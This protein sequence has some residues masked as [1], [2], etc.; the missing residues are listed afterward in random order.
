MIELNALP[1]PEESVQ[2]VSAESARRVID[3]LKRQL[4]ATPVVSRPIE[5]GS[6]AY[7]LGLAFSE[8]PGGDPQANSRLALSCFDVAAKLFSPQAYPVL[9]ARVIN[10]AGITLR[11][12]GNTEEAVRIFEHAAA[13]LDGKE[14]F[15]ERAASLNNLGLAK[16]ESRQPMA[17]LEA[18]ESALCVLDEAKTTEPWVRASMVYNRGLAYCALGT[19]DAYENAIKDFKSV[20]QAIDRNE[21]MNLYALAWHNMGIAETSMAPFLEGDESRRH[22][23]NGIEAFREALAIYVRA[24][25]P[26]Q[27]AL[28][29]HNQSVAQIGLGDTE[30]LQRALVNLDQALNIF[31]PRLHTDSWKRSYALISKVEAQLNHRFPGLTRSDHFAALVVTSP[32]S[33]AN[34]LLREKFEYIFSLPEMARREVLLDVASSVVR[35]G[36]TLQQKALE[37]EICLLMEFPS[38]RLKELLLAQLESHRSL[39]R[40]GEEKAN[41]ALDLSIGN[42][43]NTPQRVFVRDFL[44]SVGFSRP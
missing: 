1:N 3:E 41:L 12:L 20:L 23:C 37:L 44:Y 6:V 26:Y 18:F 5:H 2:M 4:V 22:Y 9:H 19:Y 31:D 11:V 17:A 27:N 39:T 29:L 10:A 34:V 32:E 42:A 28:I 35:L 7:R 16:M 15:Q 24:E 36:P 13:L 25:F 14:E 43:L 21:A 33:E 8:F 40:E 38:E 30:Y